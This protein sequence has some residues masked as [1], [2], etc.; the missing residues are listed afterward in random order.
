MALVQNL[1]SFL[2]RLAAAADHGRGCGTGREHRTSTGMRIARVCLEGF[3][4]EIDSHITGNASVDTF[5][6]LDCFRSYPLFRMPAL[7]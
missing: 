1:L 7:P 4:P 6:L 5:C 2:S 3:M